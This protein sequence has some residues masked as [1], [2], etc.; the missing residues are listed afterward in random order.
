MIFYIAYEESVET[1]QTKCESTIID[2]NWQILWS[3]PGGYV[4]NVS[5]YQ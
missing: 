2:I 4:F 3:L 5:L 1:P